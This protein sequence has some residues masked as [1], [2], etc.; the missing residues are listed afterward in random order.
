MQINPT[1]IGYLTGRA[2]SNGAH[3]PVNRSVLYSREDLLIYLT[4]NKRV[5]HLGCADHI[6]LIKKKR[7]TGRYLHDLI[8]ANAS[9]LI[10]LDTNKA[11]LE[12]M[13]ALG[14]NDLFSAEDFPKNE[15]FDTLL[16]P[17]VIEH[18]PNVSTFLNGLRSYN[19]KTVIITTPNSFRLVNRTQF[20]S[21]FI[22]TDHRYWFSPYTLAKVLYESGFVIKEFYYTDRLAYRHPIQSYLKWRYPLCRDGL[23]VVANSE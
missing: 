3:F 18:V 16:V 23:A 5:I 1:T 11:A 7:E 8:A 14:I 6:E 4:Q 12:E 10:G 2:L 17:D 19:T 20:S 21:E 9:R 15:H 22:N 13:K